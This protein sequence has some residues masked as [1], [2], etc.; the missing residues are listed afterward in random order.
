MILSQQRNLDDANSD[1]LYLTDGIIM[2][3]ILDTYATRDEFLSRR[4]SQYSK[5]LP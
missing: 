4:E 1:T 2:S 5:N 3:S